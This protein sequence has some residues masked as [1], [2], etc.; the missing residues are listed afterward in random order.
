MASFVHSPQGR[1]VLALPGQDVVFV[2]GAIT[3]TQVGTHRPSYVNAILIQSRGAAAGQACG[4]CRRRG[5]RPFPRCVRVAGHF[6][7]ACG[8]CKWRDHAARCSYDAPG[9]DGSVAGSSPDGGSPGASG[10]G[11]AAL[12]GPRQGERRLLDAAGT[13]ND[14]VVVE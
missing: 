11:V 7:G 3:P 13:Q 2:R 1:A 10:D 4:E 14:P 9:E 12:P 8:N 6:G 5:L